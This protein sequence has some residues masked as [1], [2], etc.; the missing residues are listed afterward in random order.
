MIEV[1]VI[2]EMISDIVNEVF[3]ETRERSRISLNI[4]K[5][6]FLSNEKQ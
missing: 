4:I 1:R 2:F 6:T 5:K 3:G